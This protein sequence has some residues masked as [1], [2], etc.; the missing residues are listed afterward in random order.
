LTAGANADAACARAAAACTVAGIELLDALEDLVGDRLAE[1]L[2][3]PVAAAAVALSCEEHNTWHRLDRKALDDADGIARQHTFD[4]NDDDSD[5]DSDSPIVPRQTPREPSK[6]VQRGRQPLTVSLTALPIEVPGSGSTSTS[7]SSSSSSGSSSTSSARRR[8]S[9][10]ELWNDTA[11]DDDNSIANGA[12]HTSDNNRNYNNSSSSNNS[13]SSGNTGNNDSTSSRS[14]A[15][16]SS[17]THSED[18]N[19]GVKRSLCSDS[20]NG[21]D[22]DVT[23]ANKRR[24][25]ASST[26]NCS[27]PCTTSAA[28]ISQSVCSANM[29]V[30]SAV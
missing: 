21:D 24:R 23:H 29:S 17:A 27:M 30:E 8:L 13:G 12:S 2:L 15:A 1:A 4:D 26:G 16:A 3:D 11:V 6:L 5:S 10:S 20:S 14:S 7:N 9:A 22:T 18:S 28:C 25:G 19:R